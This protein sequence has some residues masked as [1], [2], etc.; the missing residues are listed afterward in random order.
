[1][2]LWIHSQVLRI[3]GG[4]AKKRGRA[5]AEE[6]ADT[7]RGK[8]GGSIGDMS[9]FTMDMKMGA[10]KIEFVYTTWVSSLDISDHEQLKEIV[11]SNAKYLTADNTIRKYAPFVSVYEELEA[12]HLKLWTI[13]RIW[14]GFVL[15]CFSFLKK[16]KTY[17]LNFQTY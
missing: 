7:P 14:V 13:I 17:H 16:N 1:M 9:A 3:A 11:L 15:V 10:E 12:P 5:G 6:E 4:V 8:D 2:G